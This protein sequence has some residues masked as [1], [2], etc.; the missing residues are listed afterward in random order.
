MIY[1][2]RR[3]TLT[4]EIGPA[5]RTD[6]VIVRCEGLYTDEDVIPF[7]RDLF[8]FCENK[9]I[10]NIILDYRRMDFLLSTKSIRKS[11]EKNPHFRIADYNLAFVI[12][13]NSQT[14]QRLCYHYQRD[15]FIRFAERNNLHYHKCHSVVEALNWI[16]EFSP[17]DSTI[18]A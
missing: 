14:H 18:S 9:G 17:S 16:E 6:T 15:D 5:H 1:P 13:S 7:R 12:S 10:I 3:Y 11:T 4:W 2:I 8:G